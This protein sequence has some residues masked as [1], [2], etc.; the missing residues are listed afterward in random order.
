MYPSTRF[1]PIP[2]RAL[3][4]VLFA[5]ALAV[6]V[7]VAQLIGSGPPYS[8]ELIASHVML[9]FLLPAMSFSSL[10]GAGRGGFQLT[11]RRWAVVAPIGS[12]SA[13]FQGSTFLGWDE[14]LGVIFGMAAGCALALSG[15]L[16]VVAF[17]SAPRVPAERSA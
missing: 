12:V 6:S 2:V 17:G 15:A 3:S 13:A 16:G 14:S 10:F 11:T 4:A 1:E 9:A 7:L 8:V 5:L